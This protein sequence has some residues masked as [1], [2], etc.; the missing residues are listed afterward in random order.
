MTTRPVRTGREQKIIPSA[1]LT[2]SP[3]QAN[4]YYRRKLRAGKKELLFLLR[5]QFL[6]PIW[7]RR[8]GNNSSSTSH[9]SKILPFL[10]VNLSANDGDAIERSDD[11]E[12]F[13]IRDASRA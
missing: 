5:R 10:D 13:L 9:F 3:P 6:S 7:T 2:L 11:G 1:L 12:S 4:Q 8:T